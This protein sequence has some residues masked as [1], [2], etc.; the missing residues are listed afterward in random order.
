MEQLNTAGASGPNLISR[1][2]QATSKLQTIATTLVHAKP[3]SQAHPETHSSDAAEVAS[4]APQAVLVTNIKEVDEYAKRLNEAVSEFQAV[5]QQLEDPALLEMAQLVQELTDNQAKLIQAAAQTQKP[6]IPEFQ[7]MLARIQASLESISNL[8]NSNRRSKLFNNFSAISEGVAA[9]GW[10]AIEKTPM[11]YITD[12]KESSQFYTN[13]VLKEFRESN[14]IQVEFVK[15]FLHIIEQLFLY[16]KMYHTTG[17]KFGYSRPLLTSD[18]AIEFINSSPENAHNVANNSSNSAGGPPPPP[19]PPPPPVFDDAP[20]NSDTSS[21]KPMTGGINALFSEIN[22]GEGIT[23][24]LKKV[25]KN[26]PKPP[27]TSSQPLEPKPIGKYKNSLST[28]SLPPKKELNGKRWAIE[29]FVNEEISLEITDITQTVYIYNCTGCT[30][31]ISNKLNNLSI[32]KCSKSGIIFDAVVS[33]CDLINSQSIK[34][35]PNLAIPL[36]NIDKSNGVQLFL[37]DSNKDSIEILTAKSS[38]INV[39]YTDHTSEDAYDYREFFV[40][41][42]MKTTVVDGKLI[43]TVLEHNG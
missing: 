42:Q 26:A 33:S 2:K 22:Q 12:M 14:P 37:N 28:P 8:K 31:S 25:D 11:G 36:I 38:E 17:L 20:M 24:N 30:I 32:D 10:V 18:Q 41:E 43:T 3:E 34:L 27:P 7:K 13:R 9:Y 15:K 29:N 35:Q 39:C 5:C 16:V 40:P 23:K 6:A 19:P 21:S 4:S 1:L